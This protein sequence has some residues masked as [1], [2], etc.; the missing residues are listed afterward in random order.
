MLV[1]GAV[2]REI[3]T[4]D[5]LRKVAKMP[6][7]EKMREEVVGLLSS[8][9]SQIAGILELNQQ[10]LMATLQARENAK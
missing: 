2:D 6:T 9:A 7:K 3:L 5:V 10:M 1:G 4:P 8:P